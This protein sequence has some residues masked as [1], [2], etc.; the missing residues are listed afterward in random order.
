MGVGGGGVKVT[1]GSL[2]RLLGRVWQ[3]EGLWV[4]AAAAAG[5]GGGRVTLSGA[6]RGY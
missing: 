4:A 2:L 3:K 1:L 6:G 5:G